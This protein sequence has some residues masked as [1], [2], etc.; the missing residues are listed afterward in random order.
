MEV[1]DIWGIGGQWASWLEGQGIKTA[2][3]L[4][5]AH[6]SAIRQKM[7]VVG[8]RI[9]YELQGRSCLPLE[10]VAPPRKGITVSRS[11][12]QAITEFD[13][14]REALLRHVG[15]ACEKLR[16]Q[17][18]MTKQITVF[19]MTSRFDSKRPCYSN[20]AGCRLP[21]ATDCTPEVIHYAVALLRKIYRPGLRF[22]KCGIMLLDL[23]PVSRDRRDLFD[24]RDQEKMARLMKAVDRINATE[25]ARTVH[26]GSA[27]KRHAVGFHEP[28]LYDVL[29]RAFGRAIT[30]REKMLYGK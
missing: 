26:F 21:F 28:A 25:G 29:E 3:D 24:G 12:G 27:A 10:L 8:E 2:L 20:A 1:G 22:Q 23:E 11:F 17:N 6:V 9:V 7:T 5:R 14:V 16:R 13:P 19:L 30:C 15:R 4:K 18:L